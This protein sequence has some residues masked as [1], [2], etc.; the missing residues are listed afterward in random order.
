MEADSG[1]VA[2]DRM[3]SWSPSSVPQMTEAIRAILPRLRNRLPTACLLKNVGMNFVKKFSLFR[4]GSRGF[5]VKSIPTWAMFPKIETKTSMPTSG[6]SSAT[7]R[8]IWSFVSRTALSGVIS[9]T[10]RR[11]RKCT[12]TSRKRS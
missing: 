11:S 9:T 7:I 4:S 6:A 12:S 1:S 10:A 3:R 2:R 5:V 8:K